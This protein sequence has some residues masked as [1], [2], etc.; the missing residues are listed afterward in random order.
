MMPWIISVVVLVF[1]GL[2]T[3][4][5]QRLKSEYIYGAMEGEVIERSAIIGA[6]TLYLDFL[7]LSPC[8]CRCS[9]IATSDAST[10]VVQRPR[11][12]PGPIGF[13]VSGI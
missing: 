13:W 11:L 4:D 6:L 5:T 3:Y 10:I 9:A 1:A 12:N 8:C 7:N 2:T